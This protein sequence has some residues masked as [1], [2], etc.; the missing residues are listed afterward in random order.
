MTDKRQLN[1]VDRF[2]KQPG[3]L[4]L[5]EHGHCEVP[6]GWGGVVLRWRNPRAALPLLVHVY[7]PVASSCSIDGEGLKMSSVDL[8]PGRHVAAV[9]IENVDLSAGLLLFAAVHDPERAR[10]TGPAGLVEGPVRVLSAGDGT[11]KYSLAPPPADWALPSFDDRDWPALTTAPTPTLDHD[12]FGAY[13]CRRCA[14]LGA[15]CL[16]L[17][18]PPEGPVVGTIWA[19]KAFEVPAPEEGAAGA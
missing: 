17:P 4:V 15:A 9:A 11:W 6:A 19:R 5:E 13:Q 14:E 18:V 10:S 8:A 1:S 16:R 12:A 2:R 7:T 3:R